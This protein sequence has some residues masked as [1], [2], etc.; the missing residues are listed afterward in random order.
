MSSTDVRART[1]DRPPGYR[2]TQKDAARWGKPDGRLMFWPIRKAGSS[3]YPPAGSAAPVLG[4]LHVLPGHQGQQRQR[5]RSPL[6]K[7][8]AL[9]RRR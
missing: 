2:G 3:E 7:V 6:I 1:A 9:Q 8:T 4:G 5:G